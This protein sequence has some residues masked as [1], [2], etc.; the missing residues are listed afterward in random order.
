MA[1]PLPWPCHYHGP[2][3]TM[4]LPLPWPC[5]GKGPTKAMVR[6]ASLRIL[7]QSPE[8]RCGG[9]NARCLMVVPQTARRAF[10]SFSHDCF[11]YFPFIAR[12]KSA[13]IVIFRA[14]S[15]WQ[16]TV[17]CAPVTSRASRGT[18]AAGALPTGTPATGHQ[19][20]TRAPA[21]RSLECRFSVQASTLS[22]RFLI[23]PSAPARAAAELIALAAGDPH[24]ALASAPTASGASAGE[25]AASA[26]TRRRAIDSA[27][28]RR[29]DR[30]DASAQAPSQRASP[31]KSKAGRT[32]RTGL[33]RPVLTSRDKTTRDRRVP[34]G[35]SAAPKAVLLLLSAP[36][37]A[38]G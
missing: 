17:S 34:E 6:C 11:S 21:A 29:E 15:S 3:I 7:C 14:P 30:H 33:C 1:L 10:G 4:A 18:R 5:H 12:L 36:R 16:A 9:S 38:P 8:G 27:T 19:K 2:A 20:S 13:R 35:H 31:A 23:G 22:S 26:S 28:E 32:F 37:P 25:P 24:G